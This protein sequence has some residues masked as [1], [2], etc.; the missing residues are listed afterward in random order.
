MESLGKK[1]FFC[2]LV[3]AKSEIVTVGEKGLKTIISTS[4]ERNDNKWVLLEDSKNITVHETCRKNY[5]RPSTVE[6]YKRT[7]SMMEQEAGPS[8]MQ[9]TP[10]KKTLRTEA[11]ISF[12]FCKCC[13]FC[14]EEIDEKKER[15]KPQKYPRDIYEV[16][17]IEFKDSVLNMCTERNDEIGRKVSKRLSG[18]YDLVAEE[19][20][21]HDQFSSPK[22]RNLLHFCGALTEAFHHSKEFCS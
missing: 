4:K 10:K 21:Y 15:K 9:S 18:V 12:N 5:I 6:K 17:S 8:G 3:I 20:R 2:D 19:A 1:C 16:R 14:G 13:L 11:G 7:A 22:R